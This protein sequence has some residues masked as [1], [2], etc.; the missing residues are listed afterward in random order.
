MTLPNENQDDRDDHGD[1]QTGRHDVLELK[2]GVEQL[3]K[4]DRHRCLGRTQHQA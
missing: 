4:R 3:Q 2:A 1:D